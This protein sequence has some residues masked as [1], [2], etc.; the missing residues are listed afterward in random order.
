MADGYISQIAL[1]D[2]NIYDIKDANAATSSH[3]HSLNDL[4]KKGLTTST[5]NTNNTTDLIYS[6]SAGKFFG[7]TS[8][9]DWVGLQIGTSNDRFQLVCQLV[10]DSNTLI[11]RQNDNNSVTAS[12]WSAWQQFVHTPFTGGVGGAGQIGDASNETEANKYAIPVYVAANGTATPISYKIGCD[13]PLDAVFTDTWEELTSATAGYVPTPPSTN[14]STYF[15]RG[16]A[17]WATLPTATSSAAGII[18][19]GSGSTQAAAGDHNHNNT[20]LKLDGSNNM[21]ADINIIAGDT[22]KLINFWY[23]TNKK[24][25]ASWRAGMLGS[26]SGDTNYFV[27]QSGTSNTSAT[28]WITTLRIGQN[29]YDVA[30]KNNLYTLTSTATLGTNSNKWDKVYANEYTSGEWKATTIAVGYGG[31]GTSTTP[32]AG[33]IIY[34]ST[35]SAY[36]CTTAGTT[37]QILQSNGTNAPSWEDPYEVEILYFT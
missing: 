28:E 12:N 37:G 32:A 1:P 13:V 30:V 35:T 24:A 16:D 9:Y 20:Y 3:T 21:T 17:T 23:N 11:F 33:G 4:T 14:Q 7:H 25:G 31:T 36:G 26:G 19:I 2:G 8:N 18:Q 5:I 15:L 29:T 34:G 27:I 22:D 6:S 10:A